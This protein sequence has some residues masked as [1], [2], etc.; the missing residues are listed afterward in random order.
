MHAYP[1]QVVYLFSLSLKPVPHLKPHWGSTTS[2]DMT[3]EGF[4]RILA[5][6]TKPR[7]MYNHYRNVPTCTCLHEY[8]YYATVDFFF[9]VFRTGADTARKTEQ[10]MEGI[11]ARVDIT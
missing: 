1:L 2:S 9:Q 11:P 3:S 7:Y 8:I 5:E 10:K 6:F 4:E